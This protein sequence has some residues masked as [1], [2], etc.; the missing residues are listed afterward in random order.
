MAAGQRCERRGPCDRGQAG[1]T[2]EELQLLSP[3]PL[4]LLL[5]LLPLLL[6]LQLQAAAAGQERLEQPLQRGKQT[7][8]QKPR[9]GRLHPGGLRRSGVRLPGP[10]AAE[11]PTRTWLRG[12][13]MQQQQQQQPE[14][15][16][17]QEQQDRQRRK[18]RFP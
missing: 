4:P 12:G 6:L 16:Q 10:V 15:Q 3:L 18:R 13:R 17:Q 1:Q 11:A 2:Q 8:P 5:L 9:T 14:Q 7:P